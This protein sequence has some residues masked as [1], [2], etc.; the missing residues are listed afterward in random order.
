HRTQ[1][2]RRNILDGVCVQHSNK[3]AARME[4]SHVRALRDERL[5]RPEAANAILKA[6]R[7]VFSYAVNADLVSHNPTR[8]VPYLR[9][10]SQG[11]HSWTIE[12]IQQF[13]K[14]HPIGTKARLAMALLLYT[15]QRR[16]DV[17]LF[18]RQHVRN[19]RL[20][21]TQQKNRKRNPI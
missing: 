12:E 21:F 17:I 7:Q 4:V 2:V 3:P 6:L 13:E 9:T 19:G 16:S 15:G 10:G 11:F 14:R 5:D 1:H 8:E 20:T 18:G